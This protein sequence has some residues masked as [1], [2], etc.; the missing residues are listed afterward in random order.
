[1]KDLR[2]FWITPKAG[3][4]AS[5]LGVLLSSCLSTTSNAILL[6][7]QGDP[8]F[9]L[10]FAE[11]KELKAGSQFLSKLGA[12]GYNIIMRYVAAM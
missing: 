4:T 12:C 11:Y 1:M 2:E 7:T 8:Y 10:M 6:L 9:R 3:E 5:L